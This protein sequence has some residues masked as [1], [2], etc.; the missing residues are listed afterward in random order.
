MP[1]YLLP[2]AALYSHGHLLLIDVR[3]MAS[4]QSQLVLI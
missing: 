2:D 1:P 3:C 4:T